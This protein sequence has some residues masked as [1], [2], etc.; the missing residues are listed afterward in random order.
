[1][2]YIRK[3]SEPRSLTEYKS[4]PGATYDGYREKDNVRVQL[5]EEQ[6]FLCAY[7]M[8][9]I[10]LEKMKIE[11][12]KA[13]KASDGAGT[14]YALDYRNMLGV[15][16]GNAA[17]PPAAQ[18][19]DTH[20]GN[21]E[22]FVDPRNEDHIRQIEYQSD[23][24]IFSRNERIN[25]D[26]NETLNLNSDQAFVKAGRKEAIQRLNAYLAKKQPNGTWNVSLLNNV[27]RRFI[28]K[29]NG[30]YEP[31]VGALLY[32]IDRYLKKAEK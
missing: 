25:F 12:W 28:E 20:R 4:K 9:R 10:S 19:C 3:G 16:M 29:N 27:K 11:H 5:L 6:G 17:N 15:C 14:E 22:L 21:K 26:L 7:C 24:V 13:Q 1:M 23:G 2:M 31:F 8:S 32:Y 30:R 18:T